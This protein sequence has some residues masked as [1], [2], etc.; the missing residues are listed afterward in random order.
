MKWPF[1]N[2]K[3]EQSNG[4]ADEE[5]KLKQSSAQ[6]MFRSVSKQEALKLALKE[7]S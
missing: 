2:V 5:E 3:N 4:G 6:F 7:F 1:G